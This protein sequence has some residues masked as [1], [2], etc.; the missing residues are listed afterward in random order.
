MPLLPLTYSDGS[1]GGKRLQRRCRSESAVALVRGP[2]PIVALELSGAWELCLPPLQYLRQWCQCRPLMPLSPPMGAHCPIASIA[3][4]LLLRLYWRG[5]GRAS[6]APMPMLGSREVHGFNPGNTTALPQCPCCRPWGRGNEST[7]GAKAPIPP[8][9]LLEVMESPR[10]AVRPCHDH[11]TG[12]HQ[13][14]QALDQE[15]QLR[16][17]PLGI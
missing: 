12:A 4:I 8:T 13:R 11:V 14:R 15:D 5:W 2:A 9:L 10:H 1:F 16:G 3:S 7:K 6:M 17:G